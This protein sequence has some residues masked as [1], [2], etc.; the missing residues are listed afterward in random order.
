MSHLMSPGIRILL[1]IA[2]PILY[3]ARTLTKFDKKYVFSVT[4][5]VQYEKL[6]CGLSSTCVVRHATAAS[7]V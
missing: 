2:I 7:W 4:A 3:G 6:K 1:Y 5:H